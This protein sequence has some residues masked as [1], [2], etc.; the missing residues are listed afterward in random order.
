MPRAQYVE[1]F[2][3][4]HGGWTGQARQGEEMKA[5]ELGTS[6]VIA[7][8]PFMLDS[9]H[10]PPGPSYLQILFILLT[11]YDKRAFDL[12]FPYSGVNRFVEGEYPTDFTDA[13][14]TL[15][16]RGEFQERGAKLVLLVHSRFDDYRLAHLL[17]GQPFEVLPQWSEQTVT[18]T[19]DPDQW[20]PLGGRWDRPE[21]R[22]GR[23]EQVLRDVNVDIILAHIRSRSCR[24]HPWP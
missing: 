13:K 16:L 15:R 12:Y 2:D 18:L 3:A 7:R 21:Y 6:S 10:A 22:V 4:G 14:L 8:S 23:I 19:T 24:P 20:T 5:L 17:T 9:N 11:T 1:T